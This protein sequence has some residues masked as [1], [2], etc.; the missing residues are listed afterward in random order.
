MAC[1]SCSSSVTDDL[2]ASSPQSA[3]ELLLEAMRD[4]DQQ[5]IEKLT[6]SNGLSSLESAVFADD[7]RNDV[8]SR[9]GHGWTQWEVRW[10]KQ[11]A[12]TALANLG[13]EAKE[14]GLVFKKDKDGWK[15][16]KWTPGY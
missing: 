5:N 4:G 14:A 16:E 1:I 9:L 6:T 7:D 13:P 8:L 2:A 3:W 15:L 11:D 10:V 12:R